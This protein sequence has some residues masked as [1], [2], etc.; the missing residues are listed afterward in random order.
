MSNVV[1]HS[2]PTPPEPS[3]AQ[4]MTTLSEQ[5]SRLVRDEL[6]L[7]QLE[8]KD[9]VKSAGRGAGLFSGAGIFA[10]FGFGAGVTAAIAALVIVL[11]LW[12][13]ALIVAA[14]LFIGA[15]ITA[16]LGK[17]QVDQVSPPLEKTVESVKQ[18]IHEV[19]EGRHHG[20]R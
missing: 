15:G 7:A 18:D 6:H 12:A 1:E 9:T 2:S 3:V 14:A 5:T 16:V 17:R 4:L 13:A 10:L 11:P 20:R 8:L 19:Q